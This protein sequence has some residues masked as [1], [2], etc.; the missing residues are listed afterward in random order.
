MLIGYFIHCQVMEPSASLGLD[1]CVVC[2]GSWIRQYA[3][4]NITDAFVEFFEFIRLVLTKV[5]NVFST[6]NI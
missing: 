1:T 3:I 2:K 6:M 5:L 4:N